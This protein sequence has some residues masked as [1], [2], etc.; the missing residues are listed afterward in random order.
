MEWLERRSHSTRTTLVLISLSFPQSTSCT[1]KNAMTLNVQDVSRRRSFVGI[2]QVVCSKP[3]VQWFGAKA[4]GQIS[5]Y[6]S[7]GIDA[8][9]VSS[10]VPATASIALSVHLSSQ[11]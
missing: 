7:L 6:S 3:R 11:S 2:V 8:T 10:G 9:D 1:A 4:I 5:M